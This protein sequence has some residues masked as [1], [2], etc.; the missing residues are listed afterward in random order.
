ME[1]G[2]NRLEGKLR[3]TESGCHEFAGALNKDGYGRLK[4]NGVTVYVHRYAYERAHGS[5]PE[6]LIVLHSCDNRACCNPAHL[7]AG[8]PGE[9]YR[10]MVAK[11]R[12]DRRW[13]FW[14]GT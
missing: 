5:I 12:E 10:D 14:E 3:A 11:G 9:N 6:G 1:S 2:A 8:T 13:K 7:S 4:V